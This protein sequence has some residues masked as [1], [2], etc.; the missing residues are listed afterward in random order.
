[1]PI[2]MTGLVSN[3]DTD[4]IVKELMSAQSMKKT[5]IENKITKNEWTQEKWK[6]LNT[7]LYSLYTGSISKMKLQGSYCTKKVVSSNEAKAKVT[8]SSSAVRGTHQVQI[9]KLASA[10]YVTGDRI[11]TSDSERIDENTLLS[12][13]DDSLIGEQV[14]FA[15]S[16][17]ECV[18]EITSSTTVSEFLEAAK[19]AG[20][21]ASFDK[22]Q[23]RFFISSN[24]S[25]AGNAFSITTSEDDTVTVGENKLAGLGLTEIAADIDEENGTVLYTVADSSIAMEEASN[26]QITYNG[27]IITGESNT[28]EVN[29]LTIHAYD[30]TSAGE[31]ITLSIEQDTQAVYDSIKQFV[32]DYNDVLKE[33]NTLYNA[34]SSRGYDPLTSEQKK[35]MT[36]DEVEKWEK[37]IKDSLLRRDNTLS[38]LITSMKNNVMTSV[39]YN[40]KNY[41]LSSFGIST[42]DYTEKGLLHIDGNA[43]DSKTSGKEDKLMKALNENPDAVM[44]TLSTL[45]SNLYTDLTD[46][47]KATSLSSALTFYNDKELKNSLKTYKTELSSME[48][49]LKT[50]EN[51]YYDQFTA[52]EKA[53]AKSNA[54]TNSLAS[55]MGMNG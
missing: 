34:D 39:E 32:S 24:S 12:D 54:T 27:A 51:R 50:L 38:S 7:K 43:D 18:L 52:M 33:M 30:V 9:N 25:G 49:R 10:Q 13:I 17:K 45:V 5:K 28:I 22:S 3:L 26:S 2:R 29:G 20:I 31:K 11:T 6:D 1:M 44:H 36:E 19:E 21:N 42:S 35:E 40:G 53:L 4:S 41:S 47:M 23:Q 46:K 16:E 37:K 48:E 14:R 55:L 15:T 8:A